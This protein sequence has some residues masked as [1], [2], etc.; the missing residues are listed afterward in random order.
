MQHVDTTYRRER[1]G[2]I[3][4]VV[5]G[6]G[7]VDAKAVQQYEGLLEGGAAHRDVRLASPAPRC[8][9]NADASV[10]R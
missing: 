10:R 8:S 4:V 7:V 5:G 3:H 9:T 6:L 2:N 1:N